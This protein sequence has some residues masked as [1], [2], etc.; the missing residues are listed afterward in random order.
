MLS[1]VLYTESQVVEQEMGN[2]YYAKNESADKSPKEC[3][4]GLPAILYAA[5][6]LCEQADKPEASRLN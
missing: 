2:S 5:S 1:G 6:T 3:Q 4:G